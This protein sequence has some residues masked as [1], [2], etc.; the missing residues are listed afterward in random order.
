MSIDDDVESLNANESSFDIPF[1]AILINHLP[2]YQVFL[3]RER[4]HCSSMNAESHIPFQ[5]YINSGGTK[6]STERR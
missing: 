2:K 1:D 4:V 6:N 3:T 5:N